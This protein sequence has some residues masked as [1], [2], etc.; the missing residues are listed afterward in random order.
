MLSEKNILVAKKT[1][2]IYVTVE[3]EESKKTDLKMIT[4]YSKKN[5]DEP[6]LVSCIKPSVTNFDF[7]AL[8]GSK[9][10][11][12]INIAKTNAQK[13]QIK[14]YNEERVR[15]YNFQG[16]GKVQSLDTYLGESE[17]N[18]AIIYVHD[19]TLNNSTIK[20]DV[21]FNGGK[22][23]RNATPGKLV[24]VKSKK[25]AGLNVQWRA[26]LGSA[27]DVLYWL[28]MQISGANVITKP[29]PYN[30]DYVY[31][32]SNCDLTKYQVL[33]K[34]DVFGKPRASVNGNYKVTGDVDSYG[35][36]GPIGI[37]HHETDKIL[38]EKYIGL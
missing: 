10:T 21:T 38:L 18:S 19:K 9:I 17:I 22:T 7:R 5:K 6:S 11:E 32:T 3:E 23:W 25:D 15:V 28:S 26:N 36:P 12:C 24:Q 34:E 1:G 2:I 37:Y 4:I 30:K 27:S 8:N 29:L 16:V 13:K 35:D 14:M 31:K 33:K 20:Y